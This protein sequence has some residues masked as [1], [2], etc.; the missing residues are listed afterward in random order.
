MGKEQD[1][2]FQKVKE[3][4]S[5]YPNLGMPDWNKEFHIETDASGSAVGAILFQ[6]DAQGHKIPF[7]CITTPEL[8][9]MLNASGQ[10]QNANFLQL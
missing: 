9:I 3:I 5:S 6:L 8:Y 4:L 10:Q 7:T 1:I 2:A